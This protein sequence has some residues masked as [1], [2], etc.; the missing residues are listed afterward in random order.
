ENIKTWSDD[1]VGNL[2]ANDRYQRHF[3]ELVTR[4]LRRQLQP[5]LQKEP[6]YDHTLSRMERTA[7]FFLSSA[8]INPRVD[9]RQALFHEAAVLFENLSYLFSEP[10]LSQPLGPELVNQRLIVA[11]LCYF[12]AGYEANATVLANQFNES[13]HI[14]SPIG[15]ICAMLLAKQLVVIRNSLALVL[16]DPNIQE[17]ALINELEN[18]SI[19]I[20]D[21]IYI[22]ALR[23]FYLGIA[24][25]QHWIRIGDT[26][27]SD[28]AIGRLQK[29]IKGLDACGRTLDSM[30]VRLLLEIFGIWIDRST[31]RWLSPALGGEASEIWRRYI[32]VSSAGKKPVTEFWRSQTSLVKALLEFEK[33]LVVSM[34]TSAGKTRMAEIAIINEL[35]QSPDEKVIFIVPTRA[36]ASEVERALSSR[37]PLLGFTVSALFGGYELNEFEQELLDSTNILV[38]TPEKLDLLM[39]RD[40]GFINKVSLVVIDEGHLVSNGSR[41]LR[42]E[43]IL[44][45]IKWHASRNEK[46]KLLFLSAVLPNGGE[47]ARWLAGDEQASI[48]INW[49]PT[50]TRRLAFQWG[51]RNRNDGQL[52]YLDPPG[53]DI[54]RFVPGIVNRHQVSER[55]QVLAALAIHFLQVGP[56]LVFTVRPKQ[57]ETLAITIADF[58]QD[59][60]KSTLS[61]HQ[62]IIDADIIPEIIKQVGENHSLVKCLKLGFAYHYGPLPREVRRVVERA[63]RD[64]IIL[65]VIANETLAQGVNLPIK[66]LIVDT[67]S[68]GGSLIP[69]RD[70]YNIVGRTGRAAQEI[71]GTVVFLPDDKWNWPRYLGSFI[72][73]VIEP[74]ESVI[75]QSSLQKVVPSYYDWAPI[76]REKR[77]GRVGFVNPWLTMIEVSAEKTNQELGPQIA[78]G[79]RIALANAL[80]ARLKPSYGWSDWNNDSWY[81][82]DIFL[83]ALRHVLIEQKPMAELCNIDLY[84]EERLKSVVDSQI[85]AMAAE[86]ALDPNDPDSPLSLVP[87]MLL[88]ANRLTTEEMG[89]AYGKGLKN[90]F[91]RVLDRVPNEEQRQSFNKTGLSIDGNRYLNEQ[92]PMF[93]T[94]LESW[95]EGSIAWDKLLEVILEIVDKVPDLKPGRGLKR[96]KACMKDWIA[97]KSLTDIAETHFKGDFEKAVKVTE[98]SISNSIPWGINSL[99][100]L[101][102]DEGLDPRELSIDLKNLPALVSFGV[103]RSSAAFA[104]SVGISERELA[105]QVGNAFEQECSE[106]EIG[107]LYHGFIEWFTKLWDQED[108]ILMYFDDPSIA[109]RIRTESEQRALKL[110]GKSRQRSLWLKSGSR[111]RFKDGEEVL[112]N[113]E[114]RVD[115]TPLLRILDYLYKPR[116]TLKV[117]ERIAGDIQ[118]NDYIAIWREDDSSTRIDITYISS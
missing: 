52:L 42:L 107:V 48:D 76:W 91:L 72:D 12:L 95:A 118:N 2:F 73:E 66:T 55:P 99:F 54:E 71:E 115:N 28:E 7:F 90:R 32:R 24:A 103:P 108:E 29:S 14:K 117:S 40:K 114:H 86:E 22:A 20:G 69:V 92:L 35:T 109:K 64:E 68:R 15:S 88:G 33:G 18:E 26:A 9:E 77:K 31:W 84:G 19:A 75:L 45:R 8:L 82:Q 34:P 85:I 21:V 47:I 44:S 11:A 81:W 16:Q 51:R 102:A 6:E 13:K 113:V 101:L 1:S 46:T 74:C 59:I 111:G 100:T 94:T 39:R 17:A 62:D 38:L 80:A 110:L 43:F 5:Y 93:R 60:N 4:R 67:V 106:L 57:V 50:R 37:L 23:S 56:V 89:A 70:F 41:G 10:D 25:M 97:G 58:I 53:E 78:D 27:L 112:L 96:S 63:V 30:I 79:F 98:N 61:Q 49:K 116:L 36:L 83:T 105:I 87:S 3:S 104:F 65:L